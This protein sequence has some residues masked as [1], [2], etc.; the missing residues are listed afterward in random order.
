MSIPMRLSS[1]LDQQGMRYELCAHE[2]S[3]SS[4]ETARA[5]RV[6]RHQLAKSVILEDD[7]GCVMAVVPSDHYVMVGELGRMLGRRHLRLADEARIA[8]IFDDCDRGAVPP[9]GMAWGVETVVDD[10]VEDSEVVYMEGGDHEMLLR[11]SH[12]QFHRLMSPVRH[13]H[14]CRPQMHH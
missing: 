9:V 11:M 12:D 14:F 8:S 13:G 3:R 2:R 7:D 6:P 1:Y 5:A 4:A 10:D